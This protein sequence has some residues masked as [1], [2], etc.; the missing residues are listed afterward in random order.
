VV[1]LIGAYPPPYGGNSIHIQRLHQL[2]KVKGMDCVVLN[3]YRS[4]SNLDEEGVF[5]FRGNAVFRILNLIIS[6]RRFSMVRYRIVH[7][8]V[9]ALE[10]FRYVGIPIL[11]VCRSFKKVLTIHGGDFIEVY[12]K[13][14]FLRRRLIRY[15][16]SKFDKIITVNNKQKELLIAKF[17][18]APQKI[19]M[20]P[21]FLPPLPD[22]NF[23]LSENTDLIVEVTKLKSKFDKLGLVAGYILPIYGFHDVLDALI[24]VRKL[25]VKLGLIFVFYTESDRKYESQLIERVNEIPGVLILR[26]IKPEA[27]IEVLRYC[28]VFIRPTYLD[29]DSIALREAIYLGKQ[30]IASDCVERPDGCVLFKLGDPDD[31]ARKLVDVARD[32]NLGIVSNVMVENGERILNVY[33]ELSGESWK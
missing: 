26:D 8:H 32:K 15:L 11:L 12:G 27:F 4:P 1:L 18:I 20:I 16:V 30:V 14:N 24:S 13:S 6:L 25:G 29:G 17:G 5:K 22:G 2:C 10:K 9:T 28:D 7:I 31:L 19:I 23:T 3:P 21:A 33:K